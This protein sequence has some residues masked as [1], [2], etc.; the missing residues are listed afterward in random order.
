MSERTFP[1]H[2]DQRGELVVVEGTE[3]DFP[4]RRIFTVSGVD[5][6]GPRGGHRAGCAEVLVLVTGS[7]RMRVQPG[8]GPERRH[9]LEE[10]GQSVTLRAEDYIEY[11]L[12]GA[13]SVLLV[14]CDAPYRRN[15]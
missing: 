12:G 2:R 15:R 9:V 5:G 8:E 13:G 11:D 4:L 3:L 1:V 14:L 10:P 7:A 6:G